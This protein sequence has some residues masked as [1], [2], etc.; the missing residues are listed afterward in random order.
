MQPKL[1]CVAVF[2]QSV[3]NTQKM[4]EL[5][6]NIVLI[7]RIPAEDVIKPRVQ[8]YLIFVDVLEQL[9]RSKHLSYAN[10]LSN[11]TY[12]L[13]HFTSCIYHVWALCLE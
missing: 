6:E 8:V 5:S 10:K 12:N 4:H 3:S 2:N 11:T 1:H 9:F 13:V 7:E